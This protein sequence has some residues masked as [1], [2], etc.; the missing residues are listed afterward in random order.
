MKKISIQRPKR[1]ELLLRNVFALPNA[2]KIGLVDRI[3]ASKS[4]SPSTEATAPMY[5]RHFLVFSVFPAPL[6]PVTRIDW[7]VPV[8][9]IPSRAILRERWV[10]YNSDVYGV[11]V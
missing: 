8:C 7:S 3:C 10:V 6:S 2:S 9:L 4:D 1:D 11:K 5:W